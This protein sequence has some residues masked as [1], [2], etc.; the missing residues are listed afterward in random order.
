MGW[1]VA[2]LIGAV[3]PA[4][5][6]AQAPAPAPATPPPQVW[7][8]DWQKNHCTISTG[9]PANVGV[10]LWMT[11]GDPRPDLYL[12]GSPKVLPNLKGTKLSITLLPSKRSF[13]T[14][15]ENLSEASSVHAMAGYE[16]DE[17]L[18]PAFAASSEV[19]IDGLGAPVSIPVIGAGKAMAALRQQCIDPKLAEWGIDPKVYEALRVPPTN[20]PGG[21]WWTA[22]D[23]PTEAQAGGQLGDTVIRLD[24]DVTGKVTGCAVVVSSGSKALDKASCDISLARGRLRPAIGA[25]GKPI[26]A[27]RIMPVRWRLQG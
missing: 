26:A 1:W 18:P 11:P 10:A 6:I 20:L 22:D 5:A 3:L 13:T 23:Y 14:K 27:F 9:D 4:S 17:E 25:D 8:L 16:F 19:R 21:L 2:G 24:V 15:A 12:I 7:Q